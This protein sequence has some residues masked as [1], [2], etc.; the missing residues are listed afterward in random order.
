MNAFTV[1]YNDGLIVWVK[2]SANGKSY[3]G[4]GIIDT[5]SGTSAMIKNVSEEL[6]LIPVGESTVFTAK[7]KDTVLNYVVDVVLERKV[8]LHFKKLHDLLKVL[9]PNMP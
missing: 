3:E 4:W 8:A 1:L 7:G 2:V 6:G 5:G 9:Y